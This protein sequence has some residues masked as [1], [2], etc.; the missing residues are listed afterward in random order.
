MMPRAL[1]AAAVLLASSAPAHAADRTA[2]LLQELDR[3]D[4]SAAWAV[5][6]KLDALLALADGRSALELAAVLR[7]PH[8]CIG[9]VTTQGE[10]DEELVFVGGVHANDSMG[11]LLWVDAGWWRI[12]RVPIGY[13]SG[14]RDVRRRGETREFF[15]GIGSG[16]S[17]GDIGVVGIRLAGPRASVTVHLLPGGEINDLAWIDDDHVLVSGRLTGDRLFTWGS[18]AAW[19]DGA[20]WLLERQGDAFVV[21]AQR[22]SRDPYWLTTG[23]VGALLTRDAVVMKRFATDDAVAEALALPPLDPRIYVQLWASRDFLRDE[24]MSWSVLPDAVRTTPPAGP[25]WGSFVNYDDHT[26]TIHEVRLR[27]DRANDGWIITTVE[28]IGPGGAAAES[29][30]P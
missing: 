27:F 15:A 2:T 10:G 13:M 21:V 24:H 4:R 1:L 30:V 3:C 26:R 7:G 23:L 29:L 8:D 22:Q 11:A 5:G 16:G 6:P 9:V 17:A 12:A 28:R 20:Q 25:V 18:H 19:P 14:T